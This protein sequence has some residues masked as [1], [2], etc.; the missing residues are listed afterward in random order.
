MSGCL[1][2]AHHAQQVRL[3][4]QQAQQRRHQADALAGDGHAQVEIEPVAADA[5]LDRDEPVFGLGNAIWEIIGENHGDALALQF[6]HAFVEEGQPARRRRAQA[7]SGH[8]RYP[9]AAG[10]CPGSAASRRARRRGPAARCL[11]SAS[12]SRCRV[13]QRPPVRCRIKRRPL[14][15]D[16]GETLRIIEIEHRERHLVVQ[17]AHRQDMAE[18]TP[19]QHQARGR[20]AR[21]IA[22]GAS[23]RAARDLPL[24]RQLRQAAAAPAAHRPRSAAAPSA[25]LQQVGGEVGLQFADDIPAAVSR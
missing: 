23:G 10:S 17:A 12:R 24:L 22:S 20:L 5:L 2:A 13:C 11:P 21:A 7:A 4:A 19:R 8:L 3:L 1:E 6:G 25:L 15:A 9:P 14:G 18:T 16:H